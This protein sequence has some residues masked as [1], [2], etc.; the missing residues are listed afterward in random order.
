MLIKIKVKIKLFTLKKNSKEYRE[1][2]KRKRTQKILKKRKDK[3]DK[4]M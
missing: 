1:A 4:S 3:T 2:F